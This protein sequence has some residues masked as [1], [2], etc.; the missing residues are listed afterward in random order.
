MAPE[1]PHSPS[2]IVSQLVRALARVLP[3]DE[4]AALSVF[5]SAVAGTTSDGDLRRAWRCAEWALQLAGH[6][7]ESTVNRLAHEIQEAY[8]LLKDSMY[9]FAFGASFQDG[10]GP[11]TDVQI[12]WVERA[13]AVAKETGGSL[14]WEAVP[15]RALLEELTAPSVAERE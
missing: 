9:G 13:A 5:D 3:E 2:P 15:W 12:Q 11:G 7:D 14:G 8:R 6:P 10:V 1:E 4:R